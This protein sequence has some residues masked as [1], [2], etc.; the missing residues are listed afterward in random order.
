LSALAALPEDGS[1]RLTKALLEELNLPKP[2]RSRILEALAACGT[3]STVHLSG[4]CL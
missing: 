4:S 3:R 1:F 2:Y